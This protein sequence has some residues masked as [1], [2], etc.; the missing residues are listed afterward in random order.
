MS[1]PCPNCSGFRLSSG[2]TRKQAAYS[3]RKWTEDTD[4]PTFLSEGKLIHFEEIFKSPPRPP[5]PDHTASWPSSRDSSSQWNLLSVASGVFEVS[6]IYMDGEWGETGSQ[7]C[8]IGSER[9]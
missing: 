4:G 9:Y 8:L 7:V 3:A 2:G 5:L 6:E 1:V